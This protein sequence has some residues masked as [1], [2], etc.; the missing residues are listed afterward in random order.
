MSKLV[1]FRDLGG[2]A[3]AGGKKVR[4]GRLFRSAEPVGLLA[5]DVEMLKDHGI[6]LIVDFR[7]PIEAAEA[8]VDTID[9]VSYVNFDVLADKM[10]K[11]ENTMQWAA[12]LS[13]DTA[14]ATMLGDYKA[15][16]RMTSSQKGFGDFLRACAKA[17]GAILFHCAAG[18]D[19][20]GF[21]A[22]IILK[23]L[24]VS[25]EDIYADYLKTLEE[26]KEANVQIIEKYR[27]TG[28]GESQ[29]AALSAIYG[30]KREYL[31]TA[32]AVINEE[33]GNF[34]NYITQGLGITSEEVQRIKELYLA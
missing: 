3:A 12:G 31:D 34:E 32:F 22:A 29:L 8:P 17:E 1:N 21:A 24:G 7:S 9:G 27:K 2:L 4:F 20:T 23:I 33:Y 6:T 13:P 26:R 16:I 28:L 15:F 30:L 19:R 5:E 14:E 18:K 11:W 10:I 25:D